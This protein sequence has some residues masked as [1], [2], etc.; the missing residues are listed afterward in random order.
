MGHQREFYKLL[1]GE[2]G[3][4]TAVAGSGQ[5]EI[6]YAV[7]QIGQSQVAA[8]GV[9]RGADALLNELGHSVGETERVNGFLFQ[10]NS[11]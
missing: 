9:E 10:G 7:T 4:G 2:P 11:S 5:P 3:R 8:V 6:E 1:G